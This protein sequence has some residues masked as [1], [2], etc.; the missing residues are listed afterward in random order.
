MTPTRAAAYIGAVSLLAAWFASA[1]GVIRSPRAPRVPARTTGTSGDAV[2][3]DVQAQAERLQ[4]RL[5]A[6]PTPQKPVRNPFTFP[7]R[8]RVQSTIPEPRAA[9]PSPAPEPAA[10]PE[11]EL[12]LFGVAE[13]KTPAGPVRTAMIAG[14]GDQL[15]LAKV[16]QEVA[17]RYKVKAIGAD[18]VEL[19]DTATGRIRRLALR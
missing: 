3:F 16:G 11:P 17:G 2:A 18:A 10:D 14:A 4:R 19:T 7:A 12:M 15:T 1:A 9:E 13:D 8:P 6:A 5:A